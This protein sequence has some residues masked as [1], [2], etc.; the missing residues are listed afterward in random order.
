[1]KSPLVQEEKGD[2]KDSR[3]ERKERTVLIRTVRVIEDEYDSRDPAGLAELKRELLKKVPRFWIWRKACERP[4]DSDPHA[5]RTRFASIFSTNSLVNCRGSPTF[6]STMSSGTSHI[7]HR[8]W[9]VSE[10]RWGNNR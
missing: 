9:D 8:S 2:E 6:W 3:N 5:S 7:R 4:P 10:N 1:M